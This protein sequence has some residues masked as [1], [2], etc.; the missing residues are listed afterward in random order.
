VAAV[1]E[2]EMVEEAVEAAET[3][4]AETAAAEMDSAGREQQRV[5]VVM[6][7]AAMVVAALE[8]GEMA[9]EV[10]EVAV[11]AAP[12][13]ELVVAGRK[14]KSCQQ[15]ESQSRPDWIQRSS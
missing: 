14:E 6:E 11:K 7:V 8:V 2:V 4:A 9:A 5:V 3:E 15:I 12:L 1:A 10:M 13:V